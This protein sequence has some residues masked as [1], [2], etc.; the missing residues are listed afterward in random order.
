MTPTA[1]S[2]CASGSPAA[3]SRPDGTRC[4]TGRSAG[5]GRTRRR[6][7]LSVV[8]PDQL[9][10]LL[11]TLFDED[12]F[13]S[14]HG[15]RSLSQRHTTPY[16]GAGHSRT[17][18]STTSRPSRR[19]A[20]YGGNSNW[21]GP[22]LVPDQ[23]PGDPGAAAVRPVLRPDFTVEY[24]TGSGRELTLARDRRRPDRPAGRHLAARTGRTPPGLRRRSSGCRPTPPGRTT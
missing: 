18:P 11:A 19:T 16:D 15:L 1:S 9:A 21:R 4:W 5:A 8:P 13:L 7:L 12:A 20:M 3:W 10:R 2:A 6:L 14:P 23:L 17:R 22:G 24:P